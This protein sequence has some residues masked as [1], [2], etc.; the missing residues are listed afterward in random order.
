MTQQLDLQGRKRVAHAAQAPLSA[1]LRAEMQRLL[2][3][4]LVADFTAYP[5]L[6]E[7]DTVVRVMS[8]TAHDPDT[9][10]DAA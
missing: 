7:A 6:P 4:M 8:L 5:L 10:D 9:V 3:E 1:E 2:A